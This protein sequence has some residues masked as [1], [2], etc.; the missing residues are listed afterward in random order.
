MARSKSFGEVT[1]GNFRIHSFIIIIFLLK[2]YLFTDMC[3]RHGLGMGD[4]VI[5]K[6]TQSLI[7]WWLWEMLT[8]KQAM[9]VNVKMSYDSAVRGKRGF[10]GWGDS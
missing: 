10:G 6:Q 4:T 9:T 8:N 2:K 1:P 3:A 7:C 5:K